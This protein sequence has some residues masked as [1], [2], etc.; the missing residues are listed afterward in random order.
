[1][2]NAAATQPDWNA[3]AEKFDLWLPHIAPAGETL[4]AA[5]APAAGDLILDVACGTGEPALTLAQRLENTGKI[6]ATDAAPGM[7]AAA[8]RK[9]EARTLSNIEFSCMP[10]E[11]LSFRDETF[12]KTI[13]RFGVMLF[14]DP[15]RG[16][17]EMYRVTR[18]AGRLA[19]AVWGRPETMT[20]VCW[21]WKAFKN[22]VPEEKLPPLATITSLGDP[23]TL[24][25]LLSA[26]GWHNI[27]IRTHSLAYRFPS[28]DDYWHTIEAS[29]I[30]QT[31]F[32]A[33]AA[34]ESERIRD[35]IAAY[36]RPFLHGDGLHIPHEYLVATARR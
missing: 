35:Q 22:K 18:P 15:L 23:E 28:F 29:E 32:D 13:S 3:I 9:A 21:A 16:L 10:A 36:A 33:L 1:M 2:S 19:V 24:A 14:D 8:R 5:S 6:I 34:G 17:Q 30:M 4:L 11:S 25:Q 31:Q 26:A 12:D 27:D 7:I 20:T